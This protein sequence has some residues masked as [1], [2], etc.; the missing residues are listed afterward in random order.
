[1]RHVKVTLTLLIVALAATPALAQ[2]PIN[3]TWSST[4]LGGPV[5]VGRYTEAYDTPDGAEALRRYFGEPVYEPTEEERRLL[6]VGITLALR[7]LPLSWA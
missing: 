7:H 1:M 2:P 4:D 3:G 6:Y 5:D